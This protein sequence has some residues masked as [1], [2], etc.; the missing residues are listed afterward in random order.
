V[1]GE[2]AEYPAE[3]VQLR[4]TNFVLIITVQVDL[5]NKKLFDRILQLIL[6]QM[7][8]LAS[9]RAIVESALYG[10]SVLDQIQWDGAARSFAVRLIRQ[11]QDFGEAADKKSCICIVSVM[12]GK[13]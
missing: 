2:K 9:H 1:R 5:M 8:D 4:Y 7:N 3:S 6:P 10:S 13:P 11:L 12:T